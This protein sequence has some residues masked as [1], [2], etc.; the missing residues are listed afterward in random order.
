MAASVEAGLTPSNRTDV[1]DT[2]GG[3]VGRIR[4]GDGKMAKD[5]RDSWRKDELITSRRILMDIKDKS[6]EVRGEVYEKPQ[7]GTKEIE[8]EALW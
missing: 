1:D 8:H 2:H 6:D 4:N 5:L 7:G 3:E